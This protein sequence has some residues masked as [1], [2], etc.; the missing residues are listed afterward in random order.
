M[1]AKLRL[2]QTMARLAAAEESLELSEMSAD[3]RRRLAASR[4]R[5]GKRASTPR[6]LRGKRE[7]R[8]FGKN[9]KL[10]QYKS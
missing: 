3:I 5:K 8:A 9:G 7:T 10:L 4:A 1:T 6:P 2:Q